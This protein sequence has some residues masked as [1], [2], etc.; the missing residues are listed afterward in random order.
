A[1]GTKRRLARVVH[2]VAL[3]N[4]ERI[5]DLP[6]EWAGQTSEDHRATVLLR[7]EHEILLH[8]FRRQREL[9][10]EPDL[11]RE[12]LQREII[13]LIELIDRIEREVFFPA[14]PAEYRALVRSFVADHDV[15]ARCVAANRRATANAARANV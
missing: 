8:L 9:T 12:A 1:S 5:M 2:V 14:L 3:S 4:F 10:L 11:S 6:T 13:A 15:L 7:H